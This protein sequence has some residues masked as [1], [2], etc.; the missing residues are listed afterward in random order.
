MYGGFEGGFEGGYEGGWAPEQYFTSD[1][2][3]RTYQNKNGKNYMDIRAWA[4]GRETN[5]AN[6]NKM[7]ENIY[8]SA[9]M[10]KYHPECTKTMRKTY[11]LLA[12]AAMRAMTP[13]YKWELK[14]RLAPYAAARK[15]MA[16]KIAAEKVK[17]GY[18]PRKGLVGRIAYWNA[19]QGAD[20]DS[21]N[22]YDGLFGFDPTT[23]AAY[24]VLP[25]DSLYKAADYDAYKAALKARS[26]ARKAERA[27]LSPAEYDAYRKRARLLAAARKELAKK[28]KERREYLKTSNAIKWGPY[29]EY[30]YR[31]PMEEAVD[32]LIR[33]TPDYE[34]INK[35]DIM[36]TLMAKDHPSFFKTYTGKLANWASRGAYVQPEYQGI[37]FIGRQEPDWNAAY[38]APASAAA[39]G[40]TPY[41]PPKTREGVEE[42]GPPSNKRPLT[43]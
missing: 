5:E 28:R 12:A 23:T 32:A 37:S 31:A 20:I 8:K 30:D 14:K 17:L 4:E 40:A 41:V 2:P 36:D 3:T 34:G 35:A 27:K 26:E 39:I 33:A 42:D 16:A 19:L 22:V 24:K 38:S 18:I 9:K 25:D 7:L 43:G 15:T 6:R 11:G 29:T 21:D 10:M 1:I 13:K